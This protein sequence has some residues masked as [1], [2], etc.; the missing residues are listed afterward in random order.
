MAIESI[1]N[2]G[3]TPII[4]L[5][6]FNVLPTPNTT[7]G[8]TD[9]S[10]TADTNISLQKEGAIATPSVD[11]NKMGTLTQPESSKM[12]SIAK[13]G[14][15]GGGVLA[16]AGLLYIA[17][18]G[19][20]HER[21]E[22]VYQNPTVQLALAKAMNEIYQKNPLDVHKMSYE[23]IMNARKTALRFGA[24]GDAKRLKAIADKMKGK[25]HVKREISFKPVAEPIK[26]KAVLPETVTEQAIP[27][28]QKIKGIMK[29]HPPTGS[30]KADIRETI[31]QEKILKT[32]VRGLK[33]EGFTY[34]LTDDDEGNT[35]IEYY[36][37]PRH[38]HRIVY[39]NPIDK[40]AEVFTKFHGFEPTR[41]KEVQVPDEYPDEL[42]LIGK[43]DEV[44][45]RSNK[46]N[47]APNRDGKEKTYVHDFKKGALWATDKE[48]K[49]FYLINPDLKVKPEGLVH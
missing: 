45:Y 43:A 16:I 48:G 21:Q 30:S 23:Q 34:N 42:V 22:R 25:V 28:K 4:A 18:R 49:G 36:K 35:V 44:L 7:T 38:K 41:L 33:K 24:Y 9:S 17:L 27:E 39:H 13:Y 32:Y 8:V 29:L 26:E 31:R 19:K 10:A 2:L 5:P 20:K 3:D 37:N 40:A 6:S 47:G 12:P 1:R 15:I 14:L 46:K 11:L